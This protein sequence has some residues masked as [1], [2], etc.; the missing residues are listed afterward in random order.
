[1]HLSKKLSSDIDVLHVLT[2]DDGAGEYGGPVSVAR[3]ICIFTKSQIELSSEIIAGTRLNYSETVI[4]D[5]KNTRVKVFTLLKKFP[6]SSLFSLQFALRLFLKIRHSKIVHIHAGR[7]LISFYSAWL[8][9]LQSK[10]YFI[11]THG[12]IIYD[13]RK[14]V[15]LIDFLITKRMLTKAEKV[16]YLNRSEMNELQERFALT[17]LDLLEN[18]IDV[19][20]GVNDT[21]DSFKAI[22]CSRIH[23][24][25]NIFL[26]MQI[27]D[28]ILEE[29]DD[30]EFLIYGPDGG[31]LAPLLNLLSN[32]RYSQRVKYMG[33]LRNELVLEVL[34]NASCLILPSSYDPFPVVVLESL[35]VGTPVLIS[36]ECGHSHKITKIHEL[37]VSHESDAK[38]Y[39][40]NLLKILPLSQ[41]TD[42]RLKIQREC[43]REFGL[44]GV[45]ANL[46]NDYKSA[47]G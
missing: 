7:D 6:I 39:A 31:D 13:Q 32:E 36:S 41:L 2:L 14:L 11:Q 3:Q 37:F 9:S 42:F 44:K 16:F 29:R 38:V 12:M 5:I 19:V 18:G 40:M 24:D 43:N 28:E 26:F 15:K 21:P 20:E 27:V 34:K 25:K 47:I 33:A 35:S 10:P 45:L 23:P 46:T 4:S 8:A 17:N 22:F 30:I 1:M